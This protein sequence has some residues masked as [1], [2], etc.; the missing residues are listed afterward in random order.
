MQHRRST[1][2]VSNP[3]LLAG[4]ALA[5]LTACGPP[6]PPSMPVT[7]DA[8]QDTGAIRVVSTTSEADEPSYN[9]G[10]YIDFLD[11]PGAFGEGPCPE[12]GPEL[13]ADFLDT[14]WDINRG[15]GFSRSY[16]QGFG[17]VHTTG[18]EDAVILS[19]LVSIRT[20]DNRTGD[21]TLQ[22]RDDSGERLITIEDDFFVSE[23]L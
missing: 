1:R 13:Q 17:V 14:D 10:V 6:P 20:F 4:A 11:S 16:S 23:G 15:G 9:V 22:L 5:L 7:I 18:C 3:A 8:L 21:E 19:G 12:V 2:A